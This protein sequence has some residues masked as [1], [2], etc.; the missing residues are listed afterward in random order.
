MQKAVPPKCLSES[1]NWLCLTMVALLVTA[2]LAQGRGPVMVIDGVALG[3]SRE[4]ALTTLGSEVA[5]GILAEEGLVWYQYGSESALT[6]VSFSAQDRCLRVK[7][8]S[9]V[10]DGATLSLGDSTSK[11]IRVLG[12]PKK[13][14]SSRDGRQV[15]EFEPES[16]ATL[17]LVLEENGIVQISAA[18]N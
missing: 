6:T 4:Q 17:Y 12:Q 5:S 14:A 11:V 15:L 13:I 7:G 10:L 18:L 8:S 16:Q 3:Q 2:G 1:R 9:L